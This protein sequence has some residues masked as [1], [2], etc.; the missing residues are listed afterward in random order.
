MKPFDLAKALAGEKVICR[1]GKE[2]T[3]IKK[4]KNASNP[5]VCY[6]E[7]I[8]LFSTHNLDGRHPDDSQLDLFM[9][10]TTRTYWANVCRAENHN[11][12]LSDIYRHEKEVIK[13]KATHV[14]VIKTISFEIA[15]D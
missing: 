2:V 10:P 12:Y 6:F 1:D 7:K 5:L 8:D 11:I 3:E 9:A 4:F 14:K 13:D 15:G